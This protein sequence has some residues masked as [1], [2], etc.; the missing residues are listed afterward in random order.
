MQCPFNIVKACIIL[1]LKV[2]SNP[3]WYHC[4]RKPVR[5]TYIGVGRVVTVLLTAMHT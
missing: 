5:G 3:A 1:T 2:Q 4:E